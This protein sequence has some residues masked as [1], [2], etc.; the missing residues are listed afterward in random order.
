MA[1]TQYRVGRRDGPSDFLLATTS[2]SGQPKSN[3]T[4][5]LASTMRY[6]EQEGMTC[7]YYLHSWNCHVDDAR[8][9]VVREFLGTDIPILVFVDDDVGWTA[10]DLV[11]IVKYVDATH[12]IVGGIYP[13]KEADMREA[14]PVRLGEPP[15]QADDKGLLEVVGLPTGFMAIRRDVLVAIDTQNADRRYWSRDANK[16]TERPFPIVFE[17]AHA[18][19]LRWGGDYNFCRSA[20]KLGYKSFCDPEMD[21]THE[22]AH[23]WSGHF[24]NYLRDQNGIIHPKL[25]DAWD[26]INAGEAEIDDFRAVFG[27]TGNPYSA[28]SLMVAACYKLVGSITH[29]NVLECG[30]GSTTIAMG[31]AA[32]RAGHGVTIH[33]LEHDVDWWRKTAAMIKKYKI[34]SIRLYYAP[35]E[36]DGDEAWYQVPEELPSKFDL[37]VIDGP[38]RRHGRG[39]VWEKLGSRIEDATWVMDD[40]NDQPEL[41]LFKSYTEPQGRSMEIIGVDGMRKFAVAKPKRQP[42]KVVKKEAT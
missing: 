5:S 40:V 23:Q 38:Q 36:I 3:Y 41:D 42:P 13:L 1:L 29:G 28:D 32:D 34:K 11:K 35:L 26:K 14:Y 17:R 33:T 10:Q 39:Q 12:P 21:F 9:A 8:N 15:Y 30:S 31:M 18:D 37:C 16:K 24:G 25:R 2:G 6:I 22:G 19:G 7:D 20:A 4:V 27:Y